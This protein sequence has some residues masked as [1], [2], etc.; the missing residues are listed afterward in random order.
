MTPSSDGG[1][2]DPVAGWIPP[3]PDEREEYEY[4]TPV[5]DPGDVLHFRQC[6]DLG[7]MMVDFA[8]IQM[9]PLG[10]RL[11]QVAYADIRYG[12]L[13]V[14]ILNQQGTEIGGEHLRPVVTQKD[15]DEAY[16]AAI[17]RFVEKWEEYKRRWRHG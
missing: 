9:S 10:G 8:V 13:H 11:R 12:E 15:V 4:D 3:P 7:G 5:G 2:S 1:A 17:D 16:G 14:H 6:W